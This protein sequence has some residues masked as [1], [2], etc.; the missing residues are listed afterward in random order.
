MIRFQIIERPGANLHKTLVDAMRAGELRTFEAT[1]RGRRIQ[2]K[3]LSYPGW[4]NWSVHDGMINCEVISP[5]KPGREW[6]FFS[7]FLGRLADRYAGEILGI[8]IQFPGLLSDSAKV[9]KARRRV[10]RKRPRRR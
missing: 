7:A 4:M 5:R 1:R 10:R 8:N 9:A 3:N 6:Q 2:H